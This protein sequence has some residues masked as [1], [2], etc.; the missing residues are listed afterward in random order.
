[1]SSP[2]MPEGP[3]PDLNGAGPDRNPEIDGIQQDI[4][5]TREELGETLEALTQRFDV[6]AQAKR[7]ARQLG[8]RALDAAAAT[9]SRIR[10]A[11]LSRETGAA[12]TDNRLITAAATVTVA[13]V[14]VGVISW[15]KLSRAAS[16][17]AR[18]R[19][20]IED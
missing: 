14:A 6:K 11:V 8:T 5:Q 19:R 3:G 1:M 18:S 15:R 17:V 20:G 13:A 9:G 2:T 7:T 16:I 12:P 4:D 10:H